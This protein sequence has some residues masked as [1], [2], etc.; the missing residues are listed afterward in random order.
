MGACMVNLASGDRIKLLNGET[1]TVKSDDVLKKGGQGNLYRSEVNGRDVILKWYDCESALKN[2]E[3]VVE[4]L[5]S[6]SKLDM[7]ELILPISV[8]ER[9]GNQYGYVMNYAPEKMVL[10]SEA[11]Y[12]RKHIRTKRVR[13]SIASNVARVISNIHSH[14]MSFNDLNDNNIFI[15]PKTGDICLCDCDSISLKGR[16][17]LVRGQAE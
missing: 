7:P 8:T 1:V 17:P 12:N 15:D 5:E 13:Y 10:L 16:R 4:T 14:G 6:L 2:P 11:L 3:L 9:L